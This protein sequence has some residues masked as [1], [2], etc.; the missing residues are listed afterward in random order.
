MNWPVNQFNNRTARHTR[1]ETYPLELREM[2]H[3]NP[4][5]TKCAVQFIEAYYME[6]CSGIV[7]C[8]SQL[9]QF[10]L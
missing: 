10:Q 7:L 6:S 2:K 9:Q 8:M 1:I 3:E 4:S 5:C